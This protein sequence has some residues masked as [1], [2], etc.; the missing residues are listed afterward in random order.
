M[1]TPPTPTPEEIEE[2][3]HEADDLEDRAETDGI[4][5]DEEAK[6]DGVGRVTGLVP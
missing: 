2:L 6:G 5:P 1:T 4:L 3:Q